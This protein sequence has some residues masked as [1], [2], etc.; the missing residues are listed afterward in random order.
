MERSHT[1][2][3]YDGLTIKPI[4]IT[5]EPRIMSGSALEKITPVHVVEVETYIDDDE[6]FKVTFE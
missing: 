3:A 4:C 6:G 2:K 5:C 1:K